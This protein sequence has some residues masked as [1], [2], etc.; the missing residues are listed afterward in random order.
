MFDG[1]EALIHIVYQSIPTK[2]YVIGDVRPRE[3]AVKSMYFIMNYEY[4]TRLEIDNQKYVDSLARGFVW[5]SPPPPLP[6]SF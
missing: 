4:L 1:R 6:D 5:S 3:H 2:C